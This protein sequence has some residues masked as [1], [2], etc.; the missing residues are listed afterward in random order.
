[1]LAVRDYIEATGLSANDVLVLQ[2]DAD[3]LYEEGYIE[4]M[5]A[6]AMAAGPNTLIEGITH[7]PQQF[8]HDYPGYQQLSDLVDAKAAPL[9]VTEQV[10]VTVD[11]KVSGFSLAT[12]FA[13][14]GHRREYNSQGAEL[15]AE[16]ARLFIRGKIRGGTK[17]RAEGA[18]AAPSRRKII[19]NPIR[20]FASAGF[21]R[22]ESWWCAWRTSYTGPM[23]L[24]SFKGEESRACLAPVIATRKAHLIVLFGIL[25]NVLERILRG[26]S[27]A[28]ALHPLMACVTERNTKP[29]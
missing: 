2:A 21:P 25:P 20:H 26:S 23:D 10:D 14:G 12:Y 4:A 17:I 19:E 28:A 5:R 9:F 11:D 8:L 1:M 7:P 13:W 18:F 15:H 3:T 29:A 27:A 16:T 22:E 24:V 6:A